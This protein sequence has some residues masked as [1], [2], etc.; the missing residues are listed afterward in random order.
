MKLTKL[1]SLL[2][3][4]ALCLS[5]L[6]GC[7]SSSSSSSSSKTSIWTTMPTRGGRGLLS[8]GHVSTVVSP[9]PERHPLLNCLLL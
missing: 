9:A 8:A 6:A 1:I 2:L 7:G 3:V 4:I 5:V